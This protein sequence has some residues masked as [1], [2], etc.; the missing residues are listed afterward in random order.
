M[1]Q[2]E[3]YQPEAQEQAQEQQE[4]LNRGRLDALKQGLQT[5]VLRSIESSP[6][7]YEQLKP[8]ELLKLEDKAP[9]TLSKLFI[10]NAEY[11]GNQLISGTIDFKGNYLA[12]KYI[13]IGDFQNIDSVYL[14]IT[15]TQGNVREGVRSNQAPF[16][17]FTR[18]GFVDKNGYIPIMQGYSFES[19]Q[20]QE[21]QEEITHKYEGKREKT[22]EFRE[23]VKEQERLYEE[24]SAERRLYL[25]LDGHIK[26]DSIN[27]QIEDAKDFLITL[28]MNSD[29]YIMLS[30]WIKEAEKVDKN[31]PEGFTPE[32]LNMNLRS[33]IDQVGK[34]YFSHEELPIF[35]AQIEQES[36]F[37]IF[38]VSQCG[39][40]GIAQFMTETAGDHNLD[41]RLNALHS[42]NASMQ[43]MRQDS[44][45]Y[46]SMELALIAYNAGGTRAVK[47]A[48][49]LEETNNDIQKAM[50]LAKIPKETQK[51]VPKILAK[52]EKYM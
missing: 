29:E 48:L 17:D 33:V 44:D 19:V 23:Y 21:M 5:D 51:Y 52:S 9:G 50:K 47:T 30:D 1:T 27:A 14:K 42:I 49:Y 37:N 28:N 10:K 16:G 22:P 6:E 13:G 36:N 20:I 24:T 18:H 34:K 7:E 46:G 38:A 25:M 35:K 12:L 8:S 26:G 11:N 39:A 40:K 4:V 3:S 15:D 32:M 41:N 2:F 31:L 45:Y 43:K